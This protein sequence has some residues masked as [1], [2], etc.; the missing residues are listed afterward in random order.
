ML[1]EL[2][3]RAILEDLAG[4][5]VFRRGEEYFS[6]GAV[7]RLRA[8]DDKVTARVEGT[9]TYQVELRDEDDGELAYECTCPHAADG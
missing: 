1:G 2:I 7:E 6:A 5:T 9:E 3:N 8:T 4:A